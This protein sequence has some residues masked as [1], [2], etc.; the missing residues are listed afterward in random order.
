MAVLKRRGRGLVWSLVAL[1][2]AG[3]AFVPFMKFF[4]IQLLR[5][6]HWRESV[7]VAETVRRALVWLFVG[8]N[9]TAPPTFVP[10]LANWAAAHDA[11]YSWVLLVAVA[12]FAAVA[13]YGLLARH[14]ETKRV[15]LA[16]LVIVPLAGVVAVSR[17]LP[18]FDARYM[19]P[20]VPF[21]LGAC[22]AGL[23]ALWRRRRTWGALA[24][25]WLVL[26]TGGS[27]HDYFYSP[28]HWR[29][30]WR[31]LARRLGREAGADD[32]IL[33]YNFY[34]SLA[35][36]HYY[37]KE[38]T[39]APVQYLYVL[40]ERFGPLDVKRR[41]AAD[42]L[43]GVARNERPVWLVDYHGYMDDPYDDARRG[44][45]ERGYLRATQECRLPGL[46]RYCVERW[47]FGESHLIASLTDSFDFATAPP[48]AYQLANGWLPGEG[49]RRWIGPH[50]TIRFRRPEGPSR[51]RA[52]FF[53][54]IDYLGGPVAV[55]FA[56]ND[57]PI[58]ELT[59]RQ[60][61]DAIWNSP[62]F[63][64]DDNGEPVVTVTITPN[65]VFVPA[66]VL[67]DG[68]RTPK[69]LLVRSVALEPADE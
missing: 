60:S 67:G 45:T 24:A 66:D 44:L 37:E 3:L 12:P 41:R 50:A 5:G 9:V 27:L 31:G 32:A 15:S 47:V 55:R 39:R 34:T 59:I 23:L 57:N 36:L 2:A 54:N 51:L 46:W 17:W 64:F 7:G 10:P 11:A 40:E 1:V 13:A 56:A 42:V 33:F 61:E 65:R 38:A 4:A 18:I 26:L 16:V 22:A 58:G 6:V 14:D 48:P 8:H 20:L 53:A 25:V 19:L 62:P 30:D 69:S 49:D 43:D 21:A 28:A 52:R 63:E 35:F 29:Q 68:D